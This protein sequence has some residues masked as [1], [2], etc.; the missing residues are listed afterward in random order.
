MMKNLEFFFFL[1]KAKLK[2]LLLDHQEEK[3]EDPNKLINEK[4]EIA[5]DVT[6]IQK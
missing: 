6:E 3:R 4:V 2:N 5:A 1:R